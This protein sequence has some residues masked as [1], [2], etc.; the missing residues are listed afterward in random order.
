MTL[1]N[2]LAAAQP[3]TPPVSMT[4]S[5]AGGVHRRLVDAAAGAGIT[6]E[7]MTSRLVALAAD[8]PPGAPE[9][10]AAVKKFAFNCRHEV[11]NVKGSFFNDPED[12]VIFG[13]WAADDY[14]NPGMGI[15]VGCAG[16]TDI[17]CIGLEPDTRGAFELKKAPSSTPIEVVATPP[18][19][20]SPHDDD[21]RI[22]AYGD[23]EVVF[24]HPHIHDAPGTLRLADLLKNR[25]VA[26]VGL[27]F[28][29][30]G[31]L[32]KHAPK[33]VFTWDLV[34]LD[35]MC[36]AH[37]RDDERSSIGDTP[38]AFGEALI[39]SGW[40]RRDGESFVALGYRHGKPPG[41]TPGP[42][43]GAPDGF[44][45]KYWGAGQG[46][47]PKDPT[48]AERQRRRRGKVKE[49]KTK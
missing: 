18:Q 19:A 40:L 8:L 39:E 28:A 46:Q 23:G 5:V 10:V 32:S 4:I 38:T 30:W 9:L 20:A 29:F 47:G 15:D 44:E 3:E 43:L 48:A 17:V 41:A 2:R 16:D 31:V 14:L 25:A 34:L 26:A 6:V 22:W 42:I 11:S 21:E 13:A 24:S 27:L 33:G 45:E 7:V 12:V 35:R 36:R 1:L 49:A 37:M